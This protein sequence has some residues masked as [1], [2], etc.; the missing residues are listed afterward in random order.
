ML[1]RLLSPNFDDCRGLAV[2]DMASSETLIP[3]IYML[4]TIRK[5]HKLKFKIK[6]H[7]LLGCGI[8]QPCSL[9][10]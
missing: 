7:Q 5:I 4:N 1:P 2:S 6:I 10:A 3:Y 9:N 8:T